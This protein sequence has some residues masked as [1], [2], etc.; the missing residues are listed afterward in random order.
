[1]PAIRWS[2]ALGAA[3]GLAPFTATGRWMTPVDRPCFADPG[4]ATAAR[5]LELWIAPQERY[6]G[7][8]RGIAAGDPLTSFLGWPWRV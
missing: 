8:C 1:M 4:P 5:R 2:G 7:A 3:T 6:D